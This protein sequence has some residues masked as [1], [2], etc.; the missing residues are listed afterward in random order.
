MGQ[1]FGFDH[2]KRSLDMTLPELFAKLAEVGARPRPA[3]D[4]L[5]DA[6]AARDI[7]GVKAALADDKKMPWCARDGRMP[8]RMMFEAR[9]EEAIRVYFESGAD[10]NPLLS[11]AMNFD[12]ADVMKECLRR[13][14]KVNKDQLDTLRHLPGVYRDPELL[15]LMQ[16]KGV[17]FNKAGKHD[18]PLAHVAAA[19]NSL[20]ALQFA[21][22]QKADLHA[23]VKH[24]GR[25]ALIAACNSEYGDPVEMVT[26]LLE[27]GVMPRQWTCE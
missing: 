5:A 23:V 3:V 11:D 20:A 8:I 26:K 16:E 22:D 10:L 6:I 17:K 15:K 9:Y 19:S 25:T 24:S 2:G 27:L 4:R 13:A 18:I 7:A 14:K 12:R 1:L 21:I